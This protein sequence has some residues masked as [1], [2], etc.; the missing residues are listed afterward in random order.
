MS[1][2]TVS[3]V[4]P[5]YNKEAYVARAI[6]SVLDQQRP[7]DEIIVVDDGSTD[8]SRKQL[9]L[10]RD[11]RMRILDPATPGRGPSRARNQGIRAA[12]SRWIAFLDADDVWHPYF[13][14]EVEA[15]LRRAG[16]HTGCVFTGWQ[17]MWADGSIT[18]DRYSARPRQSAFNALDFDSFIADWLAVGSCPMWTS[19]V[20]L[21]RDVLLSA[22]LFPERCYRGEDK[23]TWLRVM[24]LTD[25]MSS[26]RPCSSYYRSTSGQITRTC[27]AN[28]RHCLCP[29]LEQMI[30]RASGRRRRLLMRLFNYEVYEYAVH[31]GQ[32]ERISPEL[33][34]GFRVWLD[35]R[36]YCVLLAL[37]YLPVSIQKLLRSCFL[38]VR[39]ASAGPGSKWRTE[40]AGGIQD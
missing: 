8:G 11:S 27:T 2:D 24:A 9:E 32:K 13:I 37:T 40:A 23:D 7:V 4:I 12:T 1:F 30:S 14:A 20:V 31:V 3:A 22:G 36:R 17:N 19:A 34:R 6:Q 26:S 21:R 39:A 35:P 5:V 10:F 29:T 18:Q 28:M 38:W 15:T 33:Y 25:A 16:E